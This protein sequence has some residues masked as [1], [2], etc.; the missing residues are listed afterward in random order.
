MIT[1][2]FF[3]HLGSVLGTSSNLIDLTL[4]FGNWGHSNINITDFG[5]TALLQ[6]FPSCLERLSL[7]L[8]RYKLYLIKA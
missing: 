5:I 4:N 6:G 3:A 7:K 1:D 2:R 8:E